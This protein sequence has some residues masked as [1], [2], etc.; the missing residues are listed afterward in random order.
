MKLIWD[1]CIYSAFARGEA[2]VVDYLADQDCPFFLPAIVI[3]E[4]RYG[5]RRG[6]RRERN[7]TMLQRV[8]QEVGLQLIPVDD[9]VASFYALVCDHLARKGNLIPVNDTWIAACCMAVGGTLLTRD[10]HFTV[11]DTID[12]VFV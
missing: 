5:F 1:T 9:T 3:G 7:E 11:V 8:I 2:P 12:T 10:R 4:L 6:T